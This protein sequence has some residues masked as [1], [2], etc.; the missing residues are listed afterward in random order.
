MTLTA[1]PAHAVTSEPE[2]SKELASERATASRVSRLAVS[3]RV[4]R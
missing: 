2:A 4:I 1:G 3:E